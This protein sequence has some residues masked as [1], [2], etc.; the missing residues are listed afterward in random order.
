M[1]S[2]YTSTVYSA[3]AKARYGMMG[4]LSPTPAN[5]NSTVRFQ[6]K[7]KVNSGTIEL[8]LELYYVQK[9]Q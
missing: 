2:I 3:P 8:E 6:T 9:S 7:I 4:C 5:A 1:S